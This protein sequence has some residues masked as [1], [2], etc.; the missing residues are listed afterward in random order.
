VRGVHIV[1]KVCI[2]R[3]EMTS[4]KLKRDSVE[5]SSVEVQGVHMKELY[6]EF[7]EDRTTEGSVELCQEGIERVHRVHWGT[8]FRVLKK[9]E[10]SKRRHSQG[11]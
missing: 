5:P 9:R 6:L 7:R 10:V 11:C 1:R 8:L 4:G 3:G 2:D